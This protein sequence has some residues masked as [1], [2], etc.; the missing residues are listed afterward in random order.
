MKS[1]RNLVALAAAFGLLTVGSAL[2]Q[3]GETGEAGQTGQTGQTGQSGQTTRE[4]KTGHDQTMSDRDRASQTGSANRMNTAVSSFVT[5]AAEGGM[6]EVELGRLASQRASDDSVKQFG[7]RM[8]TDHGKAND[9]LKQ[10]ASSKGM[11]IPSSL[12]AKH[13]AA[14]DRLSKLNGA[15]FDRAY[16]Q[17][18]V[19]DHRED[20]SEFRRESQRG[21]DPEVKSF[22][23][24]TLPVLEE[25]LKQAESTLA[26]LKK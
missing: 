11:D 3:T 2:A 24:K 26:K 9:E 8:V 20:V 10:I 25:H 4:S 6:A 1:H 13:Q 7:Q 18:M 23:A 5:K 17:D 12:A 14:M 22:A 15:E 19:R 21:T 16:M